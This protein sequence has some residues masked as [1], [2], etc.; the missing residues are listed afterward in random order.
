M[1][2]P[3]GRPGGVIF[4][5]VFAGLIHEFPQSSILVLVPNVIIRWCS[6][7][8]IDSTIT[9]DNPLDSQIKVCGYL[10]LINARFVL[11]VYI[12]TRGGEL[13]KKISF[14]SVVSR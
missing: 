9:T 3:C 10:T 7:G 4:R 13:A 1:K 6:R 12:H 5:F 8:R 11:Y 2:V 14:P